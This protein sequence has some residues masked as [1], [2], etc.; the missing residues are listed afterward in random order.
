MEGAAHEGSEESEEHWK[1]LNHFWE[2]IVHFGQTVSRNLHFK[3]A[4]HQG[5][6][7]N[8]EHVI[9]TGESDIFVMS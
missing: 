7:E 6:E 4:D 5:S 9:E 8:D 1:T 2:S 3:D